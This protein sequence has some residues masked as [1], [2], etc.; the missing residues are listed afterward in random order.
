M[1]KRYGVEQ[2]VIR[3]SR[4]R[5]LNVPVILAG[6]ILGMSLLPA[7]AQTEKKYQDWIYRCEPA[8]GDVPERCFIVQTIKDTESHRDLA[9]MARG[10]VPDQ[11]DPVAIISLPLGIYLPPGI[12]LKVD[13]GEPVR[14]PVEVCDGGGC[15]TGITLKDPLRSSMKKGVTA[16]ILVQDGSRQPAGLPI[17][18]KGF[19]A[20]LNALQP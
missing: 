17:S 11:S 15:R 20:A 3:P 9:Q 1:P 12:G 14:V 5:T 4:G 16:L 2:T 10:Y 8:Q 18:L 6:I 13:E 19:T 7:S